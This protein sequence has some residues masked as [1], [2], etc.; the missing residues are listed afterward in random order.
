[1]RLRCVAALRAVVLAAGAHCPARGRRSL[2]TVR[3]RGLARPK[4]TERAL[5]PAAVPARVGRK[6]DGPRLD[7]ARALVP[8]KFHARPRVFAGG[9]DWFD[10]QR[11]EE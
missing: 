1:M 7:L 3:V 4:R 2:L 8:P 11:S 5:P 6:D 9:Q 10:T